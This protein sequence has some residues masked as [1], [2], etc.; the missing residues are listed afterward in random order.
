M[1]PLT[2]AVVALLSL[3][4]A[5]LLS[6]IAA[7]ARANDEGVLFVFVGSFPVLF[8]MFLLTVT[9]R[10][11]WC[12]RRA[13]RPMRFQTDGGALCS[14]RCSNAYDASKGIKEE[15]GRVIVARGHKGD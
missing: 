5:V 8:I 9:Y 3:C 14:L 1:Y 15:R 4:G 12:L 13:L 7:L 2:A 11:D 10:C 6:A